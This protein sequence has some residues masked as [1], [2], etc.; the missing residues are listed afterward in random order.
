MI[1]KTVVLVPEADPYAWTELV[2]AAAAALT[3]LVAVAAAIVALVQVIEARRTR[4]EQSRPYV[5]AYLVMDR[6]LLDLVIKNFGTTPARNVRVVPSKDMHRVTAQNAAIDLIRVFDS[7]PVLVPGQEW[8]TFFDSGHDLAQAQ[9]AGNSHEIYS[10]TITC[11]DWR[12]R[13]VRAE[14]FE[15][16]WHQFEAIIYGTPKTIE[17]VAKGVEKIA[18]EL[19]NLRETSSFGRGGL[20]VV[21][22]DGEQLDRDTAEFIALNRSGV[23][24]R[25]GRERV[26]QARLSRREGLPP[27]EDSSK[28]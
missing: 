22:R 7:M 3:F 10:V 2:I 4:D 27:V 5:V 8:R 24:I 12:G 21:V 19:H 20:S 23:D 11:D 14:T 15:L 28:G 16:D 25:E 1:L 17:D 6:F 18:D 13:P 26:R 9:A